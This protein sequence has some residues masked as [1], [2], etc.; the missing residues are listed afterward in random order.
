MPASLKTNPRESDAMLGKVHLTKREAE[1]LRL[2]AR[3][4]TQAQAGAAL[5]V[6]PNTVA[7]HLKSAYRKLDA[8]TAVGAVMRAM[9]LHLLGSAKAS[10]R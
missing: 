2:I 10:K 8:H 4:C 3:G 1:V 9:E 5:G 6:S 7:S